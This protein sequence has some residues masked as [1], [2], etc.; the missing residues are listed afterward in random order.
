M[1]KEPPENQLYDPS[2]NSPEQKQYTD[3]NNYSHNRTSHSRKCCIIP[4]S[5]VFFHHESPIIPVG[6]ESP[7]IPVGEQLGG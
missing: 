3:V 6:H 5:A 2:G 4:D 1:G 7:I